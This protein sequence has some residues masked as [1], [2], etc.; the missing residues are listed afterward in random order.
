MLKYIFILFLLYMFLK[1]Q[2]DKI[3]NKNYKS[4]ND[5]INLIN[6]YKM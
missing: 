4:S 6:E 5:Y 2:I 3:Q 1:F